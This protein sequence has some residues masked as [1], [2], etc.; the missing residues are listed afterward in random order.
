MQNVV[1]NRRLATLWSRTYF[2]IYTALMVLCWLMFFSGSEWAGATGLI[3]MAFYVLSL[4]MWMAG[5]L[6]FTGM[7]LFYFVEQR[8]ITEPID[9]T[10][11]TFGGLLLLLVAFEC[12]FK[13]SREFQETALSDDLLQRFR[14]SRKSIPQNSKIEVTVPPAND[15]PWVFSF[16]QQALRMILALVTAAVLAGAVLNFFPVVGT[17]NGFSTR[18]TYALNNQGFRLIAISMTVFLGMA[19]LWLISNEIRRRTLSETQSRT[20]LRNVL[21]GHLHPDLRR[22]FLRMQ[23]KR[24]KRVK[25]NV[26]IGIP[27]NSESST[28][29]DDASSVG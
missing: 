5:P 23:R 14:R 8:S 10:A 6:F 26:P 20:F 22:I 19:F 27:S 1:I 18:N 11:L 21:A 24:N 29:S 13:T 28:K 16:I 3:L 7:I 9:P 17:L 15:A 2:A 12:A 4:R 25:K